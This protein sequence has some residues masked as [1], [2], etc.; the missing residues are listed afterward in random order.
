MLDSIEGRRSLDAVGEMSYVIRMKIGQSSS[1]VYNIIVWDVCRCA[2]SIE[3]FASLS[4]PAV[5]TVFAC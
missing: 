4:I 1:L 3:G 2:G 5:K